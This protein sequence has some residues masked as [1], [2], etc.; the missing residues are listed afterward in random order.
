MNKTYIPDAPSTNVI[1]SVSGNPSEG[2]TVTL[3]CNI[4][5]GRPRNDTKSVT[6]KKGHM[7]LP[8]SSHYTPSDNGKVLT[9]SS[10]NH[11]VDDGNYSCAATND[12]G[13]GNFSAKFQ[14][15]INCKCNIYIIFYVVW[16]FVT[17]RCRCCIEE[18]CE[19]V[20]VARNMLCL[21]STSA[22]IHMYVVMLDIYHEKSWIVEVYAL[23]DIKNYNNLTH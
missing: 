3:T 1:K 13:M 15:Q 22:Y 7:T 23:Y 16:D 21:V 11:T 9:I 5:D 6:W 14:L 20:V 19:S 4:T 2:T 17:D 10:L 8:S 18:C 12:A